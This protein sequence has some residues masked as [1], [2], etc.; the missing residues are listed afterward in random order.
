MEIAQ[1]KKLT[2]NLKKKKKK[3][4]KNIPSPKDLPDTGIKPG[5]LALQVSPTELSGKPMA[6]NLLANN[7]Q[8]SQP[9]IFL[10]SCL[11]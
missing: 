9:S 8:L 10:Q 1:G 11:L 4:K 2:Q 3:K 6:V 5:S 7:F